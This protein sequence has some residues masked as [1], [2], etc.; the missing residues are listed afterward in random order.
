[1]LEIF[2]A[3]RRSANWQCRGNAEQN[4]NTILARFW[5]TVWTNSQPRWCRNRYSQP[6]KRRRL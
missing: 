1:M 4:S 2:A 3:H 5:A 6:A